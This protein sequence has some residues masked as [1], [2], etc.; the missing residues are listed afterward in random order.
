MDEV[1]EFQGLWGPLSIAEEVIQ[2]V[3]AHQDFYTQ[4]LKTHTG[5]RLEV[6]H[7]GVWN[8]LEG[9]DFLKARMRIEGREVVGDVEI[10]YEETDW[11]AHGHQGD[12]HYD[13]VVLHVLVFPPR[14]P[15]TASHPPH[16][17]VL[18]PYLSQDIE[19]YAESFALS[20]WDTQTPDWLAQF[21]SLNIRER[22]ACLYQYARARWERKCVEH[23]HAVATYGFKVT[24]HMRALEVLGYRRNR[25]PMLELGKAFKPADIL[26]E[27]ANTLYLKQKSLW[28]LRGMRPANHPRKR[29]E[30]YQAL[31][32]HNQDWV[33]QALDSLRCIAFQEGMFGHTKIFR[34]ACGLRVLWSKVIR[35]I[36]GGC[37]PES[38]AQ[39]LLV[40]L[41]LPLATVT[42][43]EDFFACWLHAYPGDVATQ[44]VEALKRCGLVTSEN[45][46]NNGFAQGM[47]G[48]AYDSGGML[49]L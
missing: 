32:R 12:R 48:L 30:Q 14:K 35:E 24:A 45:P 37:I 6:L 33:S 16:V 1:R 36:W 39:T 9:P 44:V 38:R 2:W 22:V 41:I 29:I 47:L 43:E 4:E 34:K 25:A 18:L 23:K 15:E 42:S 10:H 46:L 11:R 20:R 5:Q 31:I 17:I 28:R 13:S 3:W 8:H 21:E 40:D 7:P 19:G 49:R 27:D 26:K